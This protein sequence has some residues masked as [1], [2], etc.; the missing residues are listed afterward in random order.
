MDIIRYF[1]FHIMH[2]ERDFRKHLTI[3]FHDKLKDAER[4]YHIMI[5]KKSTCN[6]IFFNIMSKEHYYSFESDYLSVVIIR[7]NSYP[8]NDKN[9]FC[10]RLRSIISRAINDL[11]LSSGDKFDITAYLPSNPENFLLSRKKSF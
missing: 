7:D 4:Y 11:L 5:K 8:D 6:Y 2:K 10:L 3:S 1:F 9:L